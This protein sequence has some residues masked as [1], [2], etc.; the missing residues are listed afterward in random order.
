MKRKEK[1]VMLDACDLSPFEGNLIIGQIAHVDLYEEYFAYIKHLCIESKYKET[2]QVDELGEEYAAFQAFIQQSHQYFQLAKN[3]S[4]DV[5]P[6]CYYY[7]FLNL[8]KA[9]LAP[10]YWQS[11]QTKFAHHGLQV[12]QNRRDRTTV[13]DCLKITDGVFSLAVDDIMYNS[14]KGSYNG[15]EIDIKG[16]LFYLPEINLEIAELYDSN[17]R[18]L[19]LTVDIKVDNNQCDVLL[20]TEKTWWLAERFSLP[21]WSPRRINP[22]LQKSFKT[23]NKKGDQSWSYALKRKLQVVDDTVANNRDAIQQVRQLL[24]S[25]APYWDTLSETGRGAIL[26]PYSKSF[27]LPVEL[28]ILGVMYYLSLLVR[29][30]PYEL[31]RLGIEDANLLWLYEC[32]VRNSTLVYY[33]LLCSRLHKKYIKFKL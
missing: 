11:Q 10:K 13:N 19:P 6:L 33:Q 32:F 30:R 23:S 4:F 31:K 28:V 20:K 25:L 24:S 1:L 3:A 21:E 14:T 29:Y 15:K 5:A 27:V 12:K 8:M 16:L 9:Y 18:Y 26:I 2:F 22:N 7:S 17:A